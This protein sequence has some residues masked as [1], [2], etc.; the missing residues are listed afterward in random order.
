MIINKIDL[1]LEENKN[2]N[3]NE[4]WNWTGG[5]TD[6]YGRV[7]H[8]GKMKLLHRLSYEY[9]NG[10]IPE[11]LFVC[12]HCDN[13]AC[14]NPSHLFV[15]TNEDNLKDMIKKGRYKN[16]ML[17]T[18]GKNAKLTIENVIQIKYMIKNG[19]GNTEISKKFNVGH[20][21]ICQIRRG[22]TWKHIQ[23]GEF[24]ET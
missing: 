2:N 21:T 6:G 4:C 8:I 15:G 5:K 16:G 13:R 20:T 1:F 24:D 12:H 23:I 19:L 3:K 9:F 18:T 7:R 22:V 14:F 10:P 11:K 17:G